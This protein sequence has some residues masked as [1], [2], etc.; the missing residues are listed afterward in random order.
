MTNETTN[1]YNI[2]KKYQPIRSSAITSL[3]DVSMKTVYKHLAI[4]LDSQKIIKT[5]TTPKVYYSLNESVANHFDELNPIDLLIEHNYI[6]VTPTGEILRGVNGFETWCNKA[7]LDFSKEKKQYY[8]LLISLNKHKKNGLINATK[9]ILSSKQNVILDNIYFSDFY[10]IGYYGKTK[11]GQLVYVGK[12]SQNKEVIGEIGSM[13]KPALINLIK[14]KNIKHIGFIPPTIGRKIQIL[15][16]LRE[17]LDIDLPILKI[18]KVKRSTMIAQKTLRKLQDRIDNA[19]K[20]I[21]VDPIQDIS[22]NVLLID[23]ATGS[24]AT[25][26]ET[27]RK[28]KVISDGKFKVYGYSI[29]GSQKGF[30]VISEV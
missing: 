22:G 1:I 26:N 28:I 7:D 16:V 11:L 23:D 10:T 15:D 17:Y 14:D 24:G 27:A 5:G 21:A 13:I 2:I 12:S 6:Y 25:L 9:K 18:T 19:S 29:V 30:D 8:K 3:A 4:L 20:N